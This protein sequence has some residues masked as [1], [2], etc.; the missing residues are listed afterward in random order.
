[1]DKPLASYWTTSLVGSTVA[2]CL[3]AGASI[4]AP[5][6][7]FLLDGPG[8]SP[9]PIAVTIISSY[10]SV[11]LAADEKPPKLSL[12]VRVVDLITSFVFLPF[13]V[14]WFWR[15]SWLVLDNYLW[16][17]TLS[18]RDINVSLG[19]G[20]IV[21][22]ICIGI[23]SEPIVAFVD[24]KITSKKLLYALGCLR[25]WILAWGTVSFW[26]VV[27]YCWDQF[28]AGPTYGSCW[29]S[30]ALGVAI[31][32]LMG[33]ASCIVAP[34]STIGVDAVPHPRCA[35]EPLFSLIP[36]PYDIL[37]FLGMARQEWARDLEKHE[38]WWHRKDVIAPPDDG[39]EVEL[40][41]IEENEEIPIGASTGSEEKR[42]DDE[43]AKEGI[44]QA[45]SSRTGGGSKRN[46]FHTVR[47][48][49]PGPDGGVFHTVRSW[50]PGPDG[51]VVSYHELQ[52]PGLGD[53]TCSEYAQR[54]S[55]NNK[56]SRTKLF[57]SR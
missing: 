45:S 55:E 51:G 43:E 54:P 46:V 26:R 39:G 11:T 6:A 50:R 37:Y 56:R 52:R 57:R 1:M 18:N 8:A 4:L 31:L 40:A 13:C 34:A 49:R 2:F 25:T 29:L 30:H 7:I 35:D 24:K 3:G 28:L 14:V 21:F 16:G 15:G 12:L 41:Q 47:S 48:W 42:L 33:A 27:W 17:F 19:W 10:Y 36:I 44:A 53:R 5:P 23:T 32:T 38:C 22:F 20:T 9:P